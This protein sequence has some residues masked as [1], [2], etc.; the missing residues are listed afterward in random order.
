MVQPAPA[1]CLNAAALCLKCAAVCLHTLALCLNGLA[2]CLHTPALCIEHIFEGARSNFLQ[3]HYRPDLPLSKKEH[4]HVAERLLAAG[5][6]PNNRTIDVKQKPGP[7]VTELA[8]SSG[9]SQELLGLLRRYED[10]PPMPGQVTSH[11]LSS[12]D[13][14]TICEAGQFNFNLQTAPDD[15]GSKS[16]KGICVFKMAGC[17]ACGAC[18]CT[19]YCSALDR[20][21]SQQLRACGG[22][23]RVFYCSESCQKKHWKQHK[24][25]CSQASPLSKFELHTYD[26]G[27][28]PPQW[29]VDA[30]V[31]RFYERRAKGLSGKKNPCPTMLQN[32]KRMFL[33][34]RTHENLL[35]I[36]ENLL[37]IYENHENL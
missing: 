28:Q 6:S 26:L 27:E 23:K 4:F 20:I 2:L 13:V 1:L 17:A 37:K 21:R 9:C 22:C 8:E 16:S 14:R 5:A 29:L 12:R 24:F 18:A 7:S 33:C 32:G 11:G 30:A 36:Y 10:R 3:V 15:P 31:A 35:K 34:T 19:D 25:E